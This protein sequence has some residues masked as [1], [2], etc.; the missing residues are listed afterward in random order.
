LKQENVSNMGTV[1]KKKVAGKT[2]IVSDK[3]VKD[4]ANDPYFIKKRETAEKFLKKAGLPEAF[5][6]PKSK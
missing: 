6:K 3:S 1:S 5:T 2:K 4:Y